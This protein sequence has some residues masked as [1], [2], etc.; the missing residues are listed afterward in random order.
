MGTVEAWDASE[1]AQVVAAQPLFSIKHI[2]DA[3]PLVL[4]A[5]PCGSAR[6]QVSDLNRILFGPVSGR[7][8]AAFGAGVVLITC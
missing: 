5:R 4:P 8:R 2:G 1:Q 3:M 6:L 7:V